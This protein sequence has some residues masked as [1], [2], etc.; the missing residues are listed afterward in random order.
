[1][2]GVL[3]EICASRRADVATA[4]AEVSLNELESAVREA[5]S[6]R[7]FLSA[8]EAAA[9]RRGHGLICESKRRS[10]SGGEL[11]PDLDAGEAARFFVEGGA[12]C[13]SVLTEP[14]FFGGG[15]SDL[16]GARAAVGV[17]VLRKDFILDAW[18]VAETRAL[19][20]DCLLLILAALDDV[21]AREL[22][23][24]ALG[25]GLDVLIEVMSFGE[26]ERALGMRS[27]L[28]GVNN[29]DLETLETDMARGSE[30]IA[31][32]VEGGEFVVGESGLR[33][34]EDLR[35][36]RDAGARGFLVGEHLMRS[37]DIAVATRELA[38]A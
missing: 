28:V 27:R 21:H 35:G 13:L 34:A 10:P 29:R 11:R 30:L 16:Q 5:E 31:L 8:L 6:A 22:E 14:R 7:P 2:R 18:Q 36:Q 32:A 37:A 38:E 20:A 33:G 26:L 15:W 24:Q 23:A 12:A 19:G 9:R 1:M 25:Y 4:K 3:S 17:P